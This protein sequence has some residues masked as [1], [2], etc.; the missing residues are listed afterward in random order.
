MVPFIVTVTLLDDELVNLA[1]V[2]VPAKDTNVGLKPFT[3]NCASNVIAL[4]VG[5]ALTRPNFNTPA[6]IVVAPV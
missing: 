6:L 1:L 3:S 5:I 4:P 2:V